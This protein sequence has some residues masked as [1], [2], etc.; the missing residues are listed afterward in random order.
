MSH[1]IKMTIA[2]NTQN[3]IEAC[4]IA[5]NKL[6]NLPKEYLEVFDREIEE[7][8]VS[9]SELSEFANN[10]SG[11]TIDSDSANSNNTEFMNYQRK[12]DALMKR[13]ENIRSI[14]LSNYIKNVE[15]KEKSNVNKILVENGILGMLALQN[16]T[17][18]NLSVTPEEL[19]KEIDEIRNSESDTS[20]FNEQ[21]EGLQVKIFDGEF[22]DVIENHLLETLALTNTPQLAMDFD[23]L[24]S[25]FSIEILR[26]HMVFKDVKD[27]LHDLGFK[28][29]QSNEEFTS[30]GEYKK[31]ATFRNH[32]NK[33]F[34]MS[35]K[36]SGVDFQMGN[37]D[38]HLCESDSE[39]FRAKLQE[40]YNISIRIVRN[41]SNARPMLKQAKLKE[42]GM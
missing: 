3:E 38:G 18:K 30:E 22:S 23:A 4:K 37:Y 39:S 9:V 19:E 7:L 29:I 33:E 21:I 25:N 26:T 12:L 2:L 11:M 8:R 42:R 20:E 13:V 34:V 40:A 14:N 24:L 16:I 17:K 1:Q 10:I 41:Q 27:I 28:E 35:F 31:N 6:N 15:E 5:E 36:P 32:L